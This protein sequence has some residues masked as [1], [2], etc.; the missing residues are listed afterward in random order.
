MFS[1]FDLSQG[2]FLAFSIISGYA[3][4]LPEIVARKSTNN[5]AAR[6]K[7]TYVNVAAAL[8]EF[9]TLDLGYACPVII[10][11]TITEKDQRFYYRRKN[12]QT[13]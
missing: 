7:S 8:S 1:F 11:I 10:F 12:C 2:F 5:A 6:V 4:S 3:A 13:K 9:D